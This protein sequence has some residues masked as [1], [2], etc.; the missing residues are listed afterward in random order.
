MVVGAAFSPPLMEG[1]SN[2]T[3]KDGNK[4]FELNQKP[5]S[6]KNH[7]TGNDHRRLVACR[8]DPC[9]LCKSPSVLLQMKSRTEGTIAASSS[10]MCLN[11]ALFGGEGR[12]K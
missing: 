5:T 2:G 6:K 12:A 11:Y 9:E 4:A 3:A 8:F 7:T 10:W 1:V